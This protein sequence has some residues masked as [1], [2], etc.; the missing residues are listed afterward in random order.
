M[1]CAQGNPMFWERNWTV[2]YNGGVTRF[3]TGALQ[4]SASW[5]SAS[6]VSQQHQDA[7]TFGAPTSDGQRTWLTVARSGDVIGA[8]FN[9]REDR[10]YLRCGNP[11]Q[12]GQPLGAILKWYQCNAYPGPVTE[13]ARLIYSAKDW[14]YTGIAAQS[15]TARSSAQFVGRIVID[16]NG[17]RPGFAL[18]PNYAQS[19]TSTRFS[20]SAGGQTTTYYMTYGEIQAFTV[21][22][23]GQQW[24]CNPMTTLPPGAVN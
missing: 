8:G 23:G 15:T 11:Y 4:Y 16:P 1:T 13:Y 14:P 19:W 2:G 12:D 18:D 3:A 17:Q 6:L 5:E 20:L 22:S 21:D 7:A 9:G 24:S 10:T